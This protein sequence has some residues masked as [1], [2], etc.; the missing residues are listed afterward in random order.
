[1]SFAL[2]HAANPEEWIFEDYRAGLEGFDNWILALQEGKAS[3]MGVR[4]SAAVWLECRK[5]AV[6]FL[7]EAKERLAGQADPL[8]DEA[9]AA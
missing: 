9:L 1:M 8:F 5:N 3:D 4:F 2:E 6:G 7:E